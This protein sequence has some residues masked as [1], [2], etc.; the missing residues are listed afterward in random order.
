MFCFVASKLRSE[1]MLCNSVV[2]GGRPSLSFISSCVCS[3]SRTA[4]LIPV[5]LAPTLMLARLGVFLQNLST[6][7]TGARLGS[8]LAGVCFGE[9][10]IRKRLLKAV[11]Q[12]AITLTEASTWTQKTAH[13]WSSE[14]KTPAEIPRIRAIAIMNKLKQSTAPILILRR[15]S[16]D[17]LRSIMTGMEIT[18]RA[19]Q[20]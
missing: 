11:G 6:A 10:L 5:N 19:H 7:E 17:D 18:A 12:T 9:L 14:P 15:M 4:V 20:K 2:D 8:F 16:K 1:W 13:V 3:L